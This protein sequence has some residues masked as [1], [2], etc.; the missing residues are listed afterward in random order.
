M[1]IDLNSEARSHLGDRHC[2]KAMQ[3][4]QG[5]QEKESKDISYS[6]PWNK[7]EDMTVPDP[8]RSR[9]CSKHCP[10]RPALGLPAVIPALD[11]APEHTGQDT[12]SWSRLEPALEL[13]LT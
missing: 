13:R 4:N 10:H 7:M 3:L 1:S 5:E 11:R 12:Y 8:S 9:Q 2:L 6:P